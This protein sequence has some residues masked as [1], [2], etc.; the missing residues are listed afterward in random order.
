MFDLNQELVLDIEHRDGNK[1]ARVHW[2]TADQWL[3]FN[4]RLKL[5]QKPSDD[6]TGSV[7]DVEGTAAAE[8]E[9]YTA[10]LIDEQPALD[11]AE[12]SE[13]IDRLQWQRLRSVE[14][15]GDVVE[16]V[17]GI[18]GTE[19]RHRLAVPTASEK[20]TYRNSIPAQVDLGRGKVMTSL[21]IAPQ[22]KFYDVLSRGSDG[23]ANGD[24][25][26]IHKS[27]AIRALLIKIDRSSDDRDFF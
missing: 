4:A 19:T 7:D 21:T 17:I 13:V 15:T 27:T 23:Y 26:P 6:G 10:I 14:R 3:R 22:V 12:R 18:P 2:P 9:L 11:P 8:E 20:R 25:P 5:I 1:Q 16:V 24:V